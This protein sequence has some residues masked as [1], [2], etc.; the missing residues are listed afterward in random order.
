MG[1]VDVGS[2]L[3]LALVA[4]ETLGGALGLDADEVELLGGVEMAEKV[5][6]VAAGFHGGGRY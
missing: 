5:L 6:E 2:V 3:V 1:L 4:Y